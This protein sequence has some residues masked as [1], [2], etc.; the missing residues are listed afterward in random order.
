MLSLKLV[1]QISKM[2]KMAESLQLLILA[3]FKFWD[4]GFHYFY[5]YGIILESE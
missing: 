1:S 5:V 2:A 4:T 3:K